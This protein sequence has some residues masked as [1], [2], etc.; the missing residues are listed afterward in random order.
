M[1]QVFGGQGGPTQ[2]FRANCRTVCPGSVSTVALVSDTNSR[3]SRGDLA[4]H[5]LRV[6]KG[7]QSPQY[8]Y[9]TAHQSGCLQAVRQLD[10]EARSRQDGRDREVPV[11]PSWQ[12]V[13]LLHVQAG[14]PVF[15]LDRHFGRRGQD[16]SA[17]SPSGFESRIANHDSGAGLRPGMPI[18]GP[19]ERPGPSFGQ[20]LLRD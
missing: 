3:V 11:R 9:G 12:A 6:G 1:R 15:L 16:L 5:L 17:D 7:C 18:P 2:R 14:I 10:I 4:V 19:G 13:D 20:T 8:G